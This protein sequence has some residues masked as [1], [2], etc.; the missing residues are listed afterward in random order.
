[1]GRREFV[2]LICAAT[3]LSR[4]TQAQESRIPRLCFL[5]F[6]PGTAQSPPARFQAF[7]DRL[8]ELGYIHGQTLSLD[9]LSADGHAEL[10]P[11]LV[12]ECIRRN[13][14]V[15]AVTTT[16]GA[17]ALKRATSV[18]PI[19]MVALGDPVGTGLVDSLA[20]PGANI[21]GMS[22]MTSA[23]AAKRLQLLKEAVPRLSTVLLLAY[24]VDPISPLQVQALKEVAPSLGVTPLIHDIKTPSDLPAAVELGH[25]QGANGLITTAET[26]FRAKRRTVTDLAARYKLPAIY[27]Y[28]AF[29]TDSDGLMAYEV[30]D[31]DLHRVA[32]NYVDKIL[33]GAKPADLP[34]QQPT[35]LRLVLNLKT[36]NALGLTMP[37]SILVRADE[38]IE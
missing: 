30:V 37:Q 13:P 17:Q 24:L 3:A 9:L 25:K 10:Y 22:Q 14:D 11:A 7:F 16:P 8:S 12:A 27:P 26:I 32:A 4:S 1:M 15:I 18:I 35:K 20:R 36:A 2:G 38:V 34:V 31:G 28:S 33:T 21:T 23:L 19:V 6:D 29:V 5:T